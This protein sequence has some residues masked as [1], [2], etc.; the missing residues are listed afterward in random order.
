MEVSATVLLFDVGLMVT[1]HGGCQALSR[2]EVARQTRQ[3]TDG[4][5]LR[6]NHRSRAGGQEQ[7]YHHRY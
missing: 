5:V 4:L 7:T 2:P 1:W 6:V 3:G